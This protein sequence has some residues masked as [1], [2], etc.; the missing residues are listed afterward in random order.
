[1]TQPENATNQPTQRTQTLNCVED[2]TVLTCSRIKLKPTIKKIVL[3]DKRGTKDIN[4]EISGNQDSKV[5][6]IAS[7]I[8]GLME[9][10]GFEPKLDIQLLKTSHSN[11]DPPL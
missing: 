8:M 1:M 3:T 11:P 4:I 5:R 6:L 10:K 9:D 7:G 2:A